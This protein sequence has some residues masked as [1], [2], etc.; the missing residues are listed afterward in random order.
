PII[1]ALISGAVAVAVALVDGGLV[2]AVVM[3]LI[4]LAVQQVE[5]HLLQPLLM[6]RALK[7]HPAAPPLAAATGPR[8]GEVAA[9]LLAAPVIAVANTAIKYLNGKHPVPEPVRLEFEELTARW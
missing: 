3:L 6:R 7:L 9:A 5:G 8:A 1:G 4:V 2:R